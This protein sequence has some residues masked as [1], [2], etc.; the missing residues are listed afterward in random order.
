MGRTA[1]GGRA[2]LNRRRLDLQPGACP[3]ARDAA[4][5]AGRRGRVSVG[6]LPAVGAWAVLPTVLP[7][8]L[9]PGV[10][11]LPPRRPAAR[12]VGRVLWRASRRAADVRG[13]ASPRARAGGTAG[14][15]AT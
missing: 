5:R 1:G 8:L 9:A 12:R 13:V 10:P 2:V 7:V 3:W 11:L 4:A 6:I 15:R 14:V